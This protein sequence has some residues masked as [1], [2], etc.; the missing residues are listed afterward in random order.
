MR[1][2]T[3]TGTIKRSSVF[4]VFVRQAGLDADGEKFAFERINIYFAVTGSRPVDQYNFIRFTHPQDLPPTELEFKFLAFLLLSC[5]RLVRTKRLFGFQHL[6]Q[7][8]KTRQALLRLTHLFQG[9]AHFGDCC[10]SE[11]N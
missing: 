1:S 5:G 3:Y 9:W 2:G 10:W 4:Q 6:C 11:N 7:M 8:I